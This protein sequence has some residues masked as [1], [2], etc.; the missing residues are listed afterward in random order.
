METTITISRTLGASV[1]EIMNHDMDDIITIIN[2]L[3]IAGK[4][5]P[6]PATPHAP[7]PAP[8][9]DGFWDF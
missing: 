6:A 1:L 9:N 3:L 5:N 4:N 2:Y 8:K 7:K